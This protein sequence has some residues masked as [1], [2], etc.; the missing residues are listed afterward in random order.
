MNLLYGQQQQQP[1]MQPKMQEQK[2]IVE[3]KP[4]KSPEQLRA[5]ADRI[6]LIDPK[7]F[8]AKVLSLRQQARDMERT[9]NKKKKLTE[10]ARINFL[11]EAGGNIDKAKKLALDAGYED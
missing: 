5:L 7:R 11:M 9:M 8:K 4:Q 2:P 1:M 6:E 3:A 10:T